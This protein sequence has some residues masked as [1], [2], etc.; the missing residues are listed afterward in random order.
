MPIES[1]VN[2]IF[3]KGVFITNPGLADNWF[4][5]SEPAA[6]DDW[7][8]EKLGLPPGRSNPVR[9]AFNHIREF[10]KN[11][12][13]AESEAPSGTAAG[14]L[15][16]MFGSELGGAGS[17]GPVNPETPGPSGGG[18]GGGRRRTLALLDNEQ[19]NILKREGQSV[20]VEFRFET[21]GEV[22]EGTNVSVWFDTFI[23]NSDG[24]VE[25]S[26]PL[27]EGVPVV[28]E[29][30]SLPANEKIIE[31]TAFGKETFPAGFSVVVKSP[32]NA[33]IGCESKLVLDSGRAD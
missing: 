22:Q 29:I 17:W 24:K 14:D 15:A 33:L 3:T 32:D 9:I 23:V 6:H 30:R 7:H 1:R 2:G 10:F 12:G 18:G 8:P 26:P 27:G 28:T 19:P 25:S 5:T 4:R 11:Q 13:S 21:V 31:G 16:R 20:F